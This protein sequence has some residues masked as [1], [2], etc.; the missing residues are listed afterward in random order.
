[1]K[2]GLSKYLSFLYLAVV[3]LHVSEIDLFGYIQVLDLSHLKLRG[4]HV[5]WQVQRSFCLYNKRPVGQ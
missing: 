5:H 3:K 2:L 1:M 4:I